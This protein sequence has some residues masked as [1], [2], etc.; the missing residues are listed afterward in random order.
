MMLSRKGRFTPALFFVC[1]LLLLATSAY[2]ERWS[3]SAFSDNRS[4]EAGFRNVLQE[5]KADLPADPKFPPT[6]FVVGIGDI[7]PLKATLK[8]HNEIL[9]SSVPFIPVRGN[10]EAP[11]D[12]QLIL[13]EILPSAKER[14]TSYDKTSVTFYYD[15]KNVR[16]IAVDQYAPYAKGLRDQ[17]FLDWLEKAIVSAKSADHVF[18]TFHEPYLPDSFH[19]DPFWGLLLK[20]TNKVRAVLCG[21]SHVYVRRYVPDT[22]GGIHIINAGNAGNIGHSD[23]M[24]TFVQISVD[25]KDVLFR[26]VQ[27]RD[28]SK[29]FK[30]T[31]EW[32]ATAPGE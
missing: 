5:I 1:L 26:A 10:H 27:A 23:Q 9:G 6:E 8:N 11:G 20:H 30:V 25:K 32:K 14:L 24:N 7:D 3:F 31:D 13:K 16:I 19:T 2:A 18:V 22:Y 12:V 15:W 28:K 21:H 29:D 17:A 4:F